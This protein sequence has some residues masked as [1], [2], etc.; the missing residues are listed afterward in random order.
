M[1]DDHNRL[2]GRKCRRYGKQEKVGSS[3]K[4]KL[5]DYRYSASRLKS[6]LRCQLLFS[7]KVFAARLGGLLECG[8]NDCVPKTANALTRTVQPGYS[9]VRC[10]LRV[11]Q[12]K[13]RKVSLPGR[14][15]RMCQAATVKRLAWAPR[16]GGLQK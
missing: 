2:K 14:L 13:Q 11:Q 1:M 9:T 16:V 6:V 15:W 8:P 10:A 4:G 3:E 12:L 7:S 5:Q